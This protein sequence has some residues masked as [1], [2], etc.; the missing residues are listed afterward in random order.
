MNI[1]A[2]E[3]HIILKSKSRIKE[4]FWI[5]EDGDFWVESCIEW[6]VSKVLD[7]VKPN[8]SKEKLNTIIEEKL[9]EVVWE[10]VLSDLW[11]AK[12]DTYEDKSLLSERKKSKKAQIDN[13]ISK[14]ELTAK[15]EK[16]NIIDILTNKDLIKIA[17]FVLIENWFNSPVH[18][19]ESDFINK[20]KWDFGL[21][22]DFFKLFELISWEKY[23]T[24]TSITTILNFVN[25]LNYKKKTAIYVLK[26]VRSTWILYNEDLEKLWYKKFSDNDFSNWITWKKII[27]I[28][29]SRDINK[30]TNSIYREFLDKILFDKKEKIVDNTL[31]IKKIQA[32]TGIKPWMWWMQSMWEQYLNK[33][34]YVNN[35]SKEELIKE[36]KKSLNNA[37]I[38]KTL[39][40]LLF[41]KNGKIIWKFSPF[42]S[43][44]NLYSKL[45]WK[46]HIT[47]LN[48]DFLNDFA[49]KYLWFDSI[50][51]EVWELINQSSLEWIDT[52]EKFL[53]EEFYRELSIK[54]NYLSFD[55]NDLIKII[56]NKRGGFAATKENLYDFFLKIARTEL[57]K[58][59]INQENINKIKSINKDEHLDKKELLINVNNALERNDCTNIFDLLIMKNQS[60]HKWNF[61]PFIDFIHLYNVYIWK[62]IYNSSS[63][64]VNMLKYMAIKLKWDEMDI[65]IE[66]KIKLNTEE[67]RKLKTKEEIV[68]FWKKVFYKDQHWNTISWLY[69]IKTYLWINYLKQLTLLNLNKFLYD[70]NMEYLIKRVD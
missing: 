27:Q 64:S 8:I 9:L 54:D 63:I 26:L 11:L 14:A 61:A 49:Q 50:E 12:I 47:S 34:S 37:G 62:K 15:I 69:I 52:I 65:L 41:K 44:F 48:N 10:D 57:I 23:T 46:T 70:L 36:A 18:F 45:T 2:I 20:T 60:Y 4:A 19:F 51:K 28:V 16:K 5:T 58:I 17:S 30:V 42:T 31:I 13:I 43:F 39:D 32:N 33:H 29:L 1:K 66:K 3:N 21:F 40:L 6:V 53:K 24:N 55:W 25:K 68:D 7:I 22:W 35:L 38:N 56:L 59:Y 67:I